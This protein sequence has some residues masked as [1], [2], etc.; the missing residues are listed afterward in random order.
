MSASIPST[1]LIEASDRLAWSMAWA[2]A[3]VNGPTEPDLDQALLEYLEQNLPTGWAVS[4]GPIVVQWGDDGEALN[5]MFAAT[6]SADPSQVY[7]AISGTN[8]KSYF[9]WIVEDGLVDVAVDWPVLADPVPK[10]SLGTAI[11][12]LILLDSTPSDRV[13]QAGV[14][15]SD[16]LEAQ[17]AAEGSLSPTFTGHSLG[18]ALCPSL[19]MWFREWQGVPEGWDPEDAATI[20]VVSFA[21][22]TPGDDVFAS[23]YDE[24]LGDQTRRWWNAIDIV[25]H[26]W[27][28]AMLA[29][30][31]SLYNPQ[32]PTSL[33]IEAAVDFAELWSSKAGVPYTQLTASTGS[34]P[35]EVQGGL[36]DPSK[37]DADNFLTQAVWQHTC[38]YRET[39]A[40]PPGT[41]VADCDA[42]AAT[43]RM[44][45]SV[46][47]KLAAAD[48]A[49]SQVVAATPVT[50][51]RVGEQLVKLDE[52][53]KPVADRLKALAP[54]R[55]R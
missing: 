27:E 5:S 41:K 34:F 30:I 40:Q 26:A 22:P 44:A 14:S 54:R 38:A 25:P 37:S 36:V 29:E 53:A 32:I 1:L 3:Q 35:S 46:L 12:L 45:K 51:V 42:T 6:N 11:G 17:V 20:S 4:W 55:Q 8:P 13:L 7:V 33:E 31:P 48:K 24:A 21:G 52:A 47:D 43:I 2:S 19:A 16:W 9:D 18:G 39:F 10:I 49:P 50:R 23:F 28:L 15:L